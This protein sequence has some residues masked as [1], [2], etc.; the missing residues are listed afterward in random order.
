MTS[1]LASADPNHPHEQIDVH[2]R[3]DALENAAA[4]VL[5]LHGRGARAEGILQLANRL[6]IPRVAYLAPQ[7][8]RRTWYP[9]S[10]MAPIDANEPFLTSALRAVGGVV[11]RIH[12]S[13]LPDERIVLAGFSQGACLALEYAARNPT[14]YG[15][16]V[17]FSGGLIGP[18]DHVFDY[19]GSLDETPVFLGCSDQD[20]HIPLSRVQET[21]QI[22]EALDAA[23]TE[24]IYPEMGHTV[25]DDEIS[26]MRGLLADLVG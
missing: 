16:V 11:D 22:F 8:R 12:G 15:G 26:Y 5:L 18:E 10:F 21:A 2:E 17:A 9:Y 4:A 24:R 13:G 6:E 1:P 14:R 19:E 7:A 3:G 20:P 25:N 23:V